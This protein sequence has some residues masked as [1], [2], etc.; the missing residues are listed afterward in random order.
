MG[1]S[2]FLEQRELP[3][4]VEPP[5]AASQAAY[6]LAPWMAGFGVAHREVVGLLPIHDVN[7]LTLSAAARIRD[8]RAIA[9]LMLADPFLRATDIA[10]SLANS[11]VR[12]ITNYPTIQMVDGE[13]S[14]AFDSAKLGVQREI[15]MLADL[16]TRG[17][18]TIGFAASGE[19][20]RRL[21]A[22]G[23][24]AIVFHPGLATTEWRERADAALRV[25]KMVDALRGA[26]D[27]RIMIYRPTGFGVELD[28]AA[29]RA[30]GV[31]SIADSIGGPA[32]E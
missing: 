32:R 7:G 10:A 13:T 18:R 27:G 20:A 2:D 21:V 17:I 12:W 11:G 3:V 14:R 25:E 30:D 31:V 22:G 26:W 4:L 19:V 28:K 23:A 6:V 29:T 16:A 15:D 24:A 9:G 5:R 8:P 1:S